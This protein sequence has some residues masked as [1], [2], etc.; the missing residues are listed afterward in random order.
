[1]DKLLRLMVF[2]GEVN[3]ETEMME[4]RR[5]MIVK[6]ELYMMNMHR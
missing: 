1:M 6:Y 4:S 2:R 3:G 5:E